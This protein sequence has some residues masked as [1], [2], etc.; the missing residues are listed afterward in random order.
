[1]AWSREVRL[2]F[3]DHRLVEFCLSLPTP[4]LLRGGESKRVLRHAMRGTV[5]DE[6]LDR[7]DKVGFQAPWKA[8]W[9]SE[10]AAGLHDRLSAAFGAFDG[11]ID[12]SAIA[13]GSS[14]ALVVMTLAQSRSALN[15][16]APF[17]RAIEAPSGA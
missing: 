12:P 5:P 1:M 3:L 11:L 10:C 7:R 2:P 6:I 13:P 15:G 17:A 8:W 9:S 14:D 16:F 4:Y